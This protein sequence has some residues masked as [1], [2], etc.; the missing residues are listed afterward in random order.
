MPA[1][2]PKLA[3]VDPETQAPMATTAAELELPDRTLVRVFRH[4]FRTPLLL[5]AAVEAI[6]LMVVPIVARAFLGLP[7]RAEPWGPAVSYAALN[8]VAL[9]SMGL[10]S[11]RQRSRLIGILLRV[12]AAVVI[13][14]VAVVMLSFLFPTFAL[15]RPVFLVTVPLAC[16]LLAGIRYAFESTVDEEIFKRRV[17]VYGAGKRAL[18][19][20]Q[21]RRRND[22]RGFRV[23]GYVPSE[24]DRTLVPADRLV[25][26]SGTLLQ[27]CRRHDVDEIVVAMDDRRRAFPVHELLECRLAGIQVTDLVDF[28]EQETG[29]VRLDVLNPSWMIFAPGFS[30]SPLRQ[31]TERL[32][33]VGASVTL[34]LLTW[35]LMLLAVLAIKL[36]EGWSAPVLYRQVR[37]GYEGR[38]FEVLKFRSM[39]VNAENGTAVWAL[40]KDPRVTRVGAFMRKTRIDEL[41]QLL[42]VLRGDMS[43]VGPRPERPEFVSALE[44]SI[45]YYRERH[46]VKPGLTGWAQLCYPYGASEQDAAE[47]LQYDLYYVKNH[48]LLFDL[49]I[50]VQ[51]AEVVLWGK[52]AR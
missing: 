21:L 45:P 8:L 44:Q 46:T 30:R 5:L 20:T 22:V 24:G 9:L 17:L 50:L 1:S 7:Q 40:K 29:K 34:L 19:V 28:L 31:L 32:M 42:N 10:Y 47:K 13:G 48:S 27:Y 51:T 37:V 6:A 38:H 26:P 41:P 23:L 3:R 36:E 39:R 15:E 43:F 12:V 49:M 4:F 11:R 18:S 33:D 2:N 16:V 35:P 14:G 25:A 52:G